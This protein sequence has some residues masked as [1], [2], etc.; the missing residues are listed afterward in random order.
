MSD[1]ILVPDRWCEDM[2]RESRLDLLIDCLRYEEYAP[3]AEKSATLFVADDVQVLVNAVCDKKKS[4]AHRARLVQLIELLGYG[5]NME[6]MHQLIRH[7]ACNCKTVAEALKK[8]IIYVD[9][10]GYPRAPLAAITYVNLAGLGRSI[11]KRR[12]PKGKRDED[13]PIRLMKEFVKRMT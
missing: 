9:L 6:Q 2:D 1:E 12:R 13:C 8:L 3:L 4:A 5:I 7:P 11:P 10:K